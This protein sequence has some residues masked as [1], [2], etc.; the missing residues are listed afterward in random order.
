MSRRAVH[1]YLEMTKD[2]RGEQ[3]CLFLKHAK[4][5]TMEPAFKNTLA[6]WVQE[7]IK[8]AYE[9]H[10]QELDP[11]EPKMHDIR[12]LANPLSASSQCLINLAGGGRFIPCPEGRVLAITQCIFKCV[13]KAFHTGN[14]GFE[15]WTH[16]FGPIRC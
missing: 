5:E 9:N 7:S 13:S 2:N 16:C 11:G 8:L 14:P 6:R 12:K 4:G 10:H 3:T 1:H 15:T